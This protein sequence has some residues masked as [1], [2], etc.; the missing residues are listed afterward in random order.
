[1]IEVG[2]MF[3]LKPTLMISS[4]YK[5]DY[6]IIVSIECGRISYRD[7]QNMDNKYTAWICDF[8]EM[9]DYRLKGD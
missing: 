4:Y 5:V 8:V 7:I 3:K 1:M 9:Y 2:Q 6:I